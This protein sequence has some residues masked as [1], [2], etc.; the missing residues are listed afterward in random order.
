MSIKTVLVVGDV[1]ADWNI[2]RL[3]NK[4][5]D[6]SIW[7]AAEITRACLQ[8][9]GA[10][11]LT[12]LLHKM[13]VDFE[14]IG[15]DLPDSLHNP[16]DDR[17]YHSYSMWK[18][19][20]V[21]QGEKEEVWRVENFLGLD[22]HCGQ[23]DTRHC[24]IPAA[25][26][27]PDKADIV[28]VDDAGLMFRNNKGMWPKAVTAGKPDW[29]VVKMS[30]PVGD[31]ALWHYIVENHASRCVVITSIT[32]LRKCSVRVSQ[33]LSWERTAQE[34]YWELRNNPYVNSLS[35][36]AHLVVSLGAAGAFIYHG[37]QGS[38]VGQA[39]LLYDP[40]CFEGTWGEGYPGGMVGSNVCLTAAVVKELAG[41]PD[42]QEPLLKLGVQQGLAMAR[43]LQILG[44][45]PVNKKGS[46]AMSPPSF[47]A[48]TLAKS[49][50]NLASKLYWRA[51]PEPGA[52]MWTI[53][54]DVCKDL[55][56]SNSPQSG[57]YY[58]EEPRQVLL[59]LAAKTVTLG[60]EKV[61]A[62]IPVARYGNLV[63][64]DRTEIEANNN[65][66]LMIRQYCL[67]PAPRPLCLT[68]FGSPGSGKSFGVKQVAASV[69][70]S[71]SSITFNVSQFDTPKDLS[72]ALHQVRDIGLG[73]KVPLVFWDEFDDQQ[74]AWLR[75]FLAPMQD[76]VFQD[77]Q[78]TYHVGKAIFVFA[79]GTSSSLE[80]FRAKLE[81]VDKDGLRKGKDFISRL[82]NSLT[83][84]GPNPVDQ[85]GEN[86]SS[87]LIRR[88][89]LLRSL[90]SRNA[91]QLL[92]DGK[93]QIDE[94]VLRAFL[95][96][97]H[98]KHGVRSMESLVQTS[99]LAG[100][101]SFEKSSLP[102]KSQMD[103]HVDADKF[104]MEINEFISRKEIMDKDKLDTIAAGL[105][106]VYCEGADTWQTEA[107]RKNFE[108][109][110]EGLKEE[111]R[112]NVLDIFNKLRRFGYVAVRAD[113]QNQPDELNEQVVELMAEMEH[114]RWMKSKISDGW[115]Y[116]PTRDD[117]N[118]KH[119]CL[120][121]WQ[122]LTDDDLT[123]WDI[124]V[125]KA[126]GRNPLPELE[127][128]KDRSLVRAIPRILGMAGMVLKKV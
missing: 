67:N 109:L 91:G 17:V 110:D 83:V 105:H 18:P 3:Y 125:L 42:P 122:E 51:V 71:I 87:Y 92:Q 38:K 126:I 57:V 107:A 14:V 43:E 100:K 106:Q 79:G 61:L 78:I 93:I 115:T 112:R 20:P 66:A 45:G 54:D 81:I 95:K 103:I 77:G 62:G 124:G 5:V 123:K 104:L 117:K 128:D 102:P 24:R 116:A 68:V 22:P 30:H 37:E 28:V 114:M 98:Y 34:L 8:P 41:S 56:G 48:E 11:M 70:K 13:A 76:G 64:A 21:K 26:D 59:D 19:Y 52:R 69:S 16:V 44:Y 35:K 120:L 32:D 6:R 27:L 12:E 29:I 9:G 63:T 7:N 33:G 50:L 39:Y 58:F 46:E 23:D 99:R 65:I 47:P 127:K 4:N 108:E 96:V 82:H 86:D 73:G 72:D 118:K 84:L 111:N 90:I 80:E 31:G 10:A 121:P 85:D 55:E 101:T 119:P 15:C 53:L 113:T 49:T 25:K 94:G 40:E 88:A 2:A 97:Q 60:H 36:C 89:I 74:C 1:T 75:S